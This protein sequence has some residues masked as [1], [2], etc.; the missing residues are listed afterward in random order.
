M[1]EP[2]RDAGKGY[3]T[4][5][6]G[7]LGFGE[8]PEVVMRSKTIKTLRRTLDAV[9]GQYIRTRDTDESGKGKCITCGVFTELECGHFVPRQYTATRWDDRNSHGQCSRCNRW[10]HGD[11]AEYYQVLVK[12][13]G[14]GTVDD[15]MRLKHQT[16]KYTRSE[17][18]ELIARYS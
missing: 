17:L 8:E 2:Y 13:L 16:R 3:G 18:E 1:F 12:K 4:K 6:Q 9:F 10:L 15:L 5:R 11:Q 14:Q 7:L